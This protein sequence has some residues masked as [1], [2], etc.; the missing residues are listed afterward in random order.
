M[1]QEISPLTKKIMDLGLKV[2]QEKLFNELSPLAQKADKD[3][4]AACDQALL[5]EGRELDDSVADCPWYY[6]ELGIDVNNSTKHLIKSGVITAL[7]P[8]ADVNVLHLAILVQFDVAARELLWL[9][10]QKAPDQEDAAYSAKWLQFM[11]EQRNKDEAVDELR[12]R[13]SY[14]LPLFVELGLLEF[15]GEKYHPQL[16]QVD[17]NRTVAFLMEALA[18]VYFTRYTDK[19]P[20]PKCLKIVAHPIVKELLPEYIVKCFGDEIF[21]K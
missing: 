7:D 19:V 13:L 20:I 11:L 12:Y 21:V 8:K 14:L 1:L 2:A 9:L 16:V 6:E 17:H 18:E 10:G 3:Y 4:N 15:D 5:A